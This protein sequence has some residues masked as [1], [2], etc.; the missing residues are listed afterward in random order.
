MVE[1]DPN[2]EKNPARR[3]SLISRQHVHAHNKEGWLGLFAENGVIQDPIGVSPLDPKG[4]GHRT[5]AQREAFWN[6][7]IANSEITITIHDSYAA[8]NE[9]AN[10]VT[11]DVVLPFGD[12]KYQQQTKGIFT[13]E[14]D[15]QGKI[16][17]LRGYWDFDE[18][19]KTMHEVS[20]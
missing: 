11:L 13:Y 2:K 20:S 7:N 6:N 12:K 19:M 15:A 14:V 4:M 17:S 3:A 8:A 9:V 1:L 18:T 16:L 5:P 10:H